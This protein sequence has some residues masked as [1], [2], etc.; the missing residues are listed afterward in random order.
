L[1]S[2][3][4]LTPN[5]D[6]PRELNSKGLSEGGRVWVEVLERSRREILILQLSERNTH[7]K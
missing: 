5:H 1:K 6:Q 3:H 2:S 4:K 7:E